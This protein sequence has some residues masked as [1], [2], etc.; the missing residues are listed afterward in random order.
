M[1]NPPHLYQPLQTISAILPH[2][3]QTKES[4]EANMSNADMPILRTRK[5][6]RQKFMAT[7]MAAITVNGKVIK[8][9]E[10]PNHPALALRTK[11]LATRAHVMSMVGYQPHTS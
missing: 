9:P 3:Q 2:H 5:K 1:L 11:P 10:P 4:P 7:N 8:D 6:G